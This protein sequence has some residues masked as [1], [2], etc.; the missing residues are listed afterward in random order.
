MIKPGD[1]KSNIARQMDHKAYIG[2]NKMYCSII[3]YICA[4]AASVD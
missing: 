4:P 2:G 1:V 3:L